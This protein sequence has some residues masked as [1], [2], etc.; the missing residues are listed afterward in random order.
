MNV[1]WV[2]LGLCTVLI[3]LLALAPTIE[4]QFKL[5]KRTKVDYMNARGTMLRNIVRNCLVNLNRNISDLESNIRQLKSRTTKL[6]RQKDKELE[7]K[8][9]THIVIREL[10]KIPGIGRV[11]TDRIMRLCFDGTLNSLNYIGNIQ[12]IGEEKS[13]AIRRWVSNTRRKMPQLLRTDIPG[14]SQIVTK[15]AVLDRDLEGELKAHDSELANRLHLRNEAVEALDP[16]ESVDASV[17]LNAHKG[18]VSSSE[19]VSCYFVGVFPEWRR[20][21]EWFKTL[22]ETYSTV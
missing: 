21:P 3:V 11:L 1:I 10:D 16:L 7:V 17:F 14:K 2:S 5:R 15:F 4:Y 6:S 8:L 22:V 20:M 9:T 18:D 13:Y 12:G 19:T